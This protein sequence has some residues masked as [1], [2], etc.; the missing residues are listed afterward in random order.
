MMDIP[1][2]LPGTQ[3]ELTT[4]EWIKNILLIRFEVIFN[5]KTF[6]EDVAFMS[7][8]AWNF[9]LLQSNRSIE[10]DTKMKIER[11]KNYRS[12]LFYYGCTNT[13]SSLT[14]CIENMESFSLTKKEEVFNII[15]LATSVSP[16][17][18]LICL[19]F[20]N[21]IRFEPKQKLSVIHAALDN[22]SEADAKVF[23]PPSWT[24]RYEHITQY[25]IVHSDLAERDRLS[26][27]YRLLDLDLDGT[28]NWLKSNKTHVMSYS[29]HH[30]VELLERLASIWRWYAW[31]FLDT[32]SL[33]YVTEEDRISFLCSIFER[34]V[35]STNSTIGAYAFK[36]L[37]H[38]NFW[39]PWINSTPPDGTKSRNLDTVTAS[40]STFRNWL[41][42]CVDDV[43]VKWKSDPRSCRWI[44]PDPSE[45]K[46]LSELAYHMCFSEEELEPRT[47]V[48]LLTHAIIETVK[49]WTFFKNPENIQLSEKWFWVVTKKFFFWHILN[50]NDSNLIMNNLTIDWG[51]ISQLYHTLSCLYNRFWKDFIRRIQP[52]NFLN[53]DENIK[54]TLLMYRLIDQISM[55]ANITNVSAI[56][57]IVSELVWLR[58]DTITTT[59]SA[60]ALL[61]KHDKWLIRSYP[62]IISDEKTNITDL[63]RNLNKFFWLLKMKTW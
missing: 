32:F 8:N 34:D 38:Y 59:E 50:M 45:R 15:I 56:H 62:I 12:A 57:W 35:W 42:V 55:H 29:N 40:L 19:A 37:D 53:N 11:D 49:W 9:A 48:F 26:L 24:S 41:K 30:Q 58:R 27:L 17:H 7:Q 20:L 18:A 52:K 6:Q 44:I 36:Y 3:N 31:E 10:K 39:F 2:I 22:Y 61:E 43:L 1:E 13:H 16:Q 63:C 54:K 51:A 28:L 23:M 4:I 5:S 21:G 60:Q 25:V 14:R 47:N 46:N 33:K